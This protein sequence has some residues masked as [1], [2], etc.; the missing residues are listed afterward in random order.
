MTEGT[1]NALVSLL[2]E[3]VSLKLLS[4]GLSVL[5]FSIVHSD[6]DGQRSIFVDVVAMLPPPGSEK[7]LTSDIPHQV[8]VTLRGSNVRVSEIDRGDV[9]PI[10]MDLTDTNRRYFYFSTSAIDVGGAVQVVSV[11]PSTVP[12]KWVQ[13]AEKRVPVEATIEGALDEGLALREPTEVSPAEV[14][15]RGPVDAVT[16][17]TSVRTDV[18]RVDGL[19]RGSKTLTVPLQPLPD[20]V[21]YVENVM[22]DVQL[23][24]RPELSERTFRR[25]EIEAL[26]AGEARLRPETVAITLGGPKKRLEDYD[27]ELLIP[28]I[29]L[30]VDAAVG[31]HEAKVRLKGDLDDLEIVKITPSSVLV[32]R[33]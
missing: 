21:T 14:T 8:K 15:I 29:E 24:V 31:T 20:H 5:L 19:Q 27:T 4:V 2:T 23:D 25:I 10:Q 26:G 33:R 17:L 32:R 7:M 3:N 13:S 11:E 12:L 6:Q 16:E 9:G 1:P 18:V 28:Y 30:D 22:V